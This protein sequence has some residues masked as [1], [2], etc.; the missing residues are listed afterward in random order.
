MG[1]ERHIKWRGG[2][3]PQPPA[4]RYDVNDLRA[5]AKW[6][7]KV[8]IWR[9]QV[10]AYMPRREAALLLYTSLTGEAEAELEHVPIHNINHENGIDFIL[11]ALKAPMEQ[12]AVYQKRKFLTDFEQLNRYPGEGLRSFANRYRRV[13]KSLEALGVDITGMYDSEAR[14]NRLLERAKLT[15]AD[16]RLILVGSRYSLAFD[17]IADSM[18]MQ[19]PEFKAPPPVM[20][21]DGTLVSRA[22]AGKDKGAGKGHTAQQQP[23]HPGAKGYPANN[24]KGSL[25]RRVLVADHVDPE[26]TGQDASGSFEPIPEDQA[27]DDPDDQDEQGEGDDQDPDDDNDDTELQDLAQVLTVTARRLA[28]TRL[29][30]KY[31]GSKVPA[32]ELKKTHKLR[33]MRGNRTLEG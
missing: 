21:K 32:A 15:P 25:P 33:S 13:E 2:T 3:P 17:D 11:N 9:V 23:H 18:F 20:N 26:T 28:S 30:R 4:W 29:G 16:Q 24:G 31:S 22:P 6:A 7:R 19:Y 5:Y 8:E 14:G 12:K 27:E 10:S 1:P